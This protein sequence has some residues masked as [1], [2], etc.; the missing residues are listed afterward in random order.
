MSELVS[1]YCNEQ[2][3]PNRNQGGPGSGRIMRKRASHR[4][5]VGKKGRCLR[6]NDPTSTAALS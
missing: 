4:S 3:V 5:S 2:L 6:G 1:T